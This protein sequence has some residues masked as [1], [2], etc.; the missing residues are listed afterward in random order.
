MCST[1]KEGFDLFFYQAT[2]IPC[3]MMLCCCKF[4]ALS[5]SL[6][7]F[8]TFLFPQ[9]FQMFF[10]FFVLN[11]YKVLKQIGSNLHG[12]PNLYANEEEAKVIT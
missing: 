12:P 4:I 11:I 7:L 9:S 3:S 10:F 8:C 5:F 6:S 2:T 1:T